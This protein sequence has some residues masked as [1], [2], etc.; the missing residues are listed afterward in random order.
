MTIQIATLLVALIA[1][2]IGVAFKFKVHLASPR[3]MNFDVSVPGGRR[4]ILLTRTWVA[5]WAGAGALALAIA[6]ALSFGHFDMHHLA[7][8][9][10]SSALLFGAVTFN[11]LSPATGATTPTASNYGAA[12]GP[13]DQCCVDVTTDGVATTFTVTHNLNISAADITAGFPIILIEP[14]SATGIP[15]TLLLVITRPIASG[16]AVIFTCAAIA[17]TFRVRIQRPFSMGR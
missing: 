9:L 3:W 13:T 7:G 10:G 12:G 6:T 8:L 14:N 15:A 17:A 5:A 1:L 2:M 11:W 4:F 16:N